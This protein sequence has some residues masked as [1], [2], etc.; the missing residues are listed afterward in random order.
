[1]RLLGDAKQQPA[2]ALFFVKRPDDYGNLH[3]CLE[4]ITNL[5]NSIE[6]MISN[7]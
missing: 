3:N 2:N 7:G 4:K 6:Q 1:M 5:T